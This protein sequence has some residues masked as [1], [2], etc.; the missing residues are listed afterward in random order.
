MIINIYKNIRYLI[1]I[2]LLLFSCKSVVKQ[3]YEDSTARFNSYFIAN[4]NIK[5]VQNIIYDAYKWNYDEIIPI[6]SPL[7]SNNISQYSDLTNNAIE[8]ASLLI[9]R[10]PESS[11]VM[12]SYI[13]IGLSRLYNFE[14]KNA[15]ITFKYVNTKSQNIKTST[16]AL[17]YLMRSYFENNKIQESL[18][19]YNY[20]RK[21]EM[22]KKNKISFHL[23]AAFIF[24]NIKNYDEVIKNLNLIEEEVTNKNQQSKILFLIGQIY[25]EK[26]FKNEAYKYYRKC[27]K[28]NPSFE[29][30]FYTKLNLA[31]VTELTN[32]NDIK[33]IYKYFNKLLRDKKNE[34]YLD[35]LF[36][37]I[38]EFEYNQNKIDLAIIN[39]NKS[40]K[41][42][43]SSSDQKYLNYKKLA[44]INYNDFRE[45]EISKLYYD[46]TL[47]NTNR[48]NKEY[49]NLNERREILLGLVENLK[50][51]E[52]NDSLIQ[53]SLLD[54]KEINKIV[55]NYISRLKK[56]EKKREK[57]DENF[58]FNDNQQEIIDENLS[59][60]TWYFYNDVVMTRGRDEFK[61]IW[62]NRKLTDN[63]RISRKI[64]LIEM[65]ETNI[66]NDESPI[67]ISSKENNSNEIN[68]ENL[69][70]KI[71]F[72]ETEKNNLKKQIEIAYFKV[73][74]I[75]IQ[76]LN[77]FQLGK[78]Y[79]DKLLIEFNKSE[80]IPEVL[81]LLY[82]TTKEDENNIADIYKEKLL[83][84]FPNNLFTKLIINPNYE[85]D[86]FAEN[87]FLI[88]EY[89]SLFKKYENKDYDF[90]ITKSNSII[91][92]Y[93]KNGL[94]EKFILLKALANGELHGNF[95]FQLNIKKILNNVTNNDI[96]QFSKELLKSSEEVNRD[97]IFSGIPEFNQHNNEEKFYLV[98]VVNKDDNLVSKI[99]NEIN[100]MIKD[101]N[102][103]LYFINRFKY[104]KN[105]TL[106][107]VSNL[108]YE[109]YNIL[110][111]DFELRYKEKIPI[112][113]KFVIAESN[114]KILFETKSHFEYLNFIK[115][116]K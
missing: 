80:Y 100:N 31:K 44:E 72:E 10:H 113:S 67:S 6:I 87:T 94:H 81:Y 116:E 86:Q 104:T 71:P 41:S 115:N 45:Y 26:G 19:V 105:E 18:E 12:D 55:D 70:K 3:F 93:S 17:I 58:S 90:V 82:L 25:Q 111:N 15:E 42:S 112:L 54:R 38:G 103:N 21:V 95:I 4:E 43:E 23:N 63:W 30:E 78:N 2:I 22:N 77:E 110:I 47:N 85:Q 98:F 9:Q 66:K 92:N 99:S 106:I 64:K 56:E 48:E 7:D 53:L 79:F 50:L 73:G 29:L 5:K 37:E 109:K 32:S 57:L 39:Y 114:M 102:F 91:S 76:Q 49:K 27:L 11:L 34:N 40:L 59:K 52:E 75:Y 16:L 74:K 24:Q 107:V 83:N 84:D 20:L 28:N 13:L 97:Y 60:N 51:I 96:I 101:K 69:F 33:K 108:N 61:R 62:G 65:E 14:F 1:I 35:K 46:S 8:K 36:F 68:R 88:G 89:N